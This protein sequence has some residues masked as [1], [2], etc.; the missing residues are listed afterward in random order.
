MNTEQTPTLDRQAAVNGLAVVGFIALA[1]AGVWLAVYSTRFVPTVVNR[2]GEAAVYFSSVFN[3]APGTSSLSVVPTPSASSTVTAAV[4]SHTSTST[5]HTTSTAKPPATPTAGNATSSTIAVGG[6]QPATLSGLPDLAVTVDA[7]GYLTQASTESF[8]A[9][10]TVPYAGRPAVRFTIKNVGTNWSGTWRFSVA[11]PTYPAYTY[12]SDAQQSLA[13]GDS[14]EYTLGF[15]R[16]SSGADQSA[17]ISV[18]FDNAAAESNAGN[19]S[20]TA[21]F[22]VLAP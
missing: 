12:K 14:I 8:V 22:T 7:V 10:S 9:S 21:T 19:N 18:N 16:V 20:A 3:A 5:S 1:T 2:I 6:S 15:D 11:V 17:T 4:T 13:P